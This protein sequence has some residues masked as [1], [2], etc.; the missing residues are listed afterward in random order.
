VQD[1]ANVFGPNKSTFE[2]IVAHLEHVDGG[3][4]QVSSLFKSIKS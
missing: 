4:K 3:H 1:G 2:G